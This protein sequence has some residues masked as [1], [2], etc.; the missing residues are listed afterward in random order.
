MNWT[1]FVDR[2]LGRH[3]LPDALERAGLSVERHIDHFE[4]DALD[5]EWLPEVAARGWVIVTGDK[6]LLR[7]PLEVAAIR[8]SKARVLVLVGNDARAIELATN[9]VNTLDRIRE[10]LEEMDPPAVAK[11]YR[12]SPRGLV[13][14]GRPGTVERKELP[15]ESPAT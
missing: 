10:V 6:R 4:Q 12:P 8:A 14:K 13:F 5:E 11:V 7:R 3:T 2:D 15:P 1:F 9:F